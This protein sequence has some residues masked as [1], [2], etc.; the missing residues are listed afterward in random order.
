MLSYLPDV[1]Q[2]FLLILALLGHLYGTPALL[3]NLVSRARKSVFYSTINPTLLGLCKS[4]I[5]LLA[6]TSRHVQMFDETEHRDD[7]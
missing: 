3:V 4:K 2:C 6:T 1:P 5:G 7:D